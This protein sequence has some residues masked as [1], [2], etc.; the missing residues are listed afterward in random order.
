[1]QVEEEMSLLS[2]NEDRDFSLESDIPPRLLDVDKESVE[3]AFLIVAPLDA[4]LL[5]AGCF[6][7]ALL[8]ACSLP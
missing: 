1:M 2:D 3:E 7:A 8:G 4:D 6:K 5:D